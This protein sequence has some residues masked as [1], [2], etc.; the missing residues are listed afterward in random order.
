VVDK[1]DPVNLKS[2]IIISACLLGFDCRYDLKKS[3]GI[4]FKIP[5]SALL[6]PVCPEQLGGLPTPRPKS[7]FV[8]GDGECVIKGLARVINE[9]G[10]DVTENFIK[11]ADAVKRISCITRACSA[12]LKDKSPSCGTHN[13]MISNELKRGLGITAIILSGMGICIVDEYGRSI[14]EEE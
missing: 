8:G 4:K 5:K 7:M 11:G 6:I 10:A 1:S 13:V 3:S 12:I 2:P 9:E 14:A